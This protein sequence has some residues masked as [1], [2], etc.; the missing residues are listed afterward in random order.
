MKKEIKWKRKKK[1]G[2]SCL[3]F[4]AIFFSIFPLYDEKEGGKKRG[5]IFLSFIGKKKYF[6]NKNQRKKIT[7][8]KVSLLK[9]IFHTSRTHTYTFTPLLHFLPSPLSIN[10]YNYHNIFFSFSNKKEKEE[11]VVVEVEKGENNHSKIKRHPK[12]V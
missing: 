11:V 12:S 4:S 1:G 10:H 7:L 3:T 5:H 2:I 9:I 6:F 8:K